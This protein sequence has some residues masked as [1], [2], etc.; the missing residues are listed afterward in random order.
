[1][2][3]YLCMHYY[4]ENRIDSVYEIKLAIHLTDFSPTAKL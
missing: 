2:E 1:M 4:N 3:L